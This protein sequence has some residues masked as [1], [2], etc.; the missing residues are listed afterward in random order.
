MDF[1]GQM[2]APTEIFL[3]MALALKKQDYTAVILGNQFEVGL[4]STLIKRTEL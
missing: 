1:L 3:R 2:L 4:D